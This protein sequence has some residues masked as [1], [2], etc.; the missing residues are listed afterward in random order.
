MKSLIAACC[1]DT[2]R[3]A[4]G[5]AGARHRPPRYAAVDHVDLQRFMGDWYVIANIPTFI[6]RDAH[7]AVESYRLADDGRVLTT[8][9]FRRG[10]FDG[11]AQALHARWLR[12]RRQ[13]RGL[14]HAVHLARSRPTTESSG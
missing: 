12:S 13:R 1:V 7:N 14:G 3:G 2:L 6:E 8:F 11:P 10:R 9:T 4:L 5:L